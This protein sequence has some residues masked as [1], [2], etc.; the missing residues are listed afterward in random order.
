MGRLAVAVLVALAVTGCDS[1]D[2]QKDLQIMNV[3]T[4][5]Y[6]V[7]KNESGLTKIVPSIS[8]DIKN[9]SDRDIASVQLNAVFKRKGENEA[10]GEHFIRAIDANGLKAG[11][12]TM[13]IVLR[14][15]LGYTGTE[16]RLELLANKQFVD[17][18]VQVFGKQGN[19]NWAL[20]GEYPI[21]RQL[22]TE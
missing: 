16:S 9:V 6:D 19:R 11:A 10:W 1:R 12:S 8:I 14:S 4:G 20:M 3:H 5:W 15:T 18:R 17:A 13:P 2:V 7:G 21:D 22:L